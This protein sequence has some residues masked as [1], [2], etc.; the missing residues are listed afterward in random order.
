MAN[1]QYSADILDDMLRRAHE[2]TSGNSEYE[3]RALIYLNRAY[4]AFWNGGTEFDPLLTRDWWWMHREG[5]IIVQPAIET[6]TVSVTQ[7]SASITFSSGP[8]ASVAGY[9][10]KVDGHPDVFKIDTHTAAATAATLDSVYTGEDDTAAEYKLFKI[11]YDIS[12]SA[13][14][15]TQPMWAMQDEGREIKG[16]PQV[17]FNRRWRLSKVDA[18]VPD[19]FTIVDENTVR[20]NH[21]AAEDELVRVDYDYIVKPDDLTDSASEE[22]LVPLQYRHVLADLGLYFLLFDKNSDKATGI[23]G[24]AKAGL[25]AMGKEND[26]R[27]AKIGEPGQILPR[28]SRRGLRRRLLRT[29]SGVYLS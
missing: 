11:D 25:K 7:G 6:G 16:F 12:T 1:Y 5:A 13:L 2:T 24:Q 10:F 20:F 17:E 22:P 8:A 21:Y 27:W 29:G 9:H 26:S 23:L 3:T 14:R 28:A 19:E 15:I 4:R 18:G